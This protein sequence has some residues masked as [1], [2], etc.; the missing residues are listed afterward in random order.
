MVYYTETFPL[1]ATAGKPLDDAMTKMANILNFSREKG[2]LELYL[3]GILLGI[4][5]SIIVCSIY[6]VWSCT[7]NKLTYF[8]RNPYVKVTAPGSEANEISGGAEYTQLL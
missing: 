6:C 1:L 5:F 3:V 7:K 4:T 2:D 8:I